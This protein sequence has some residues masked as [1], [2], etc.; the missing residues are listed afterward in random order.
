MKWKEKIV[1]SQIV[2]DEVNYEEMRG[3]QVFYVM[4]LN[5]VKIKDEEY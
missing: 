4:E 3:S 5:V 2:K 1:G